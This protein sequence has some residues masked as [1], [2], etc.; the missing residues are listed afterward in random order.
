MKIIYTGSIDI[1][2][3]CN[4]RCRHCYNESGTGHFDEL[5]AEQLVSIAHQL[6]EMHLD[7][8]CICGGEPLVRLPEAMRVLETLR[9]HDQKMTI[10][11]VSNGLIWTQEIASRLAGAG[12]NRVQFSLDGT[13]DVSYDFIRQSG[14]RR[15]LVLDAIGYAQNA[16]MKVMVAAIPHTKNLA[17]FQE[18]IEL[19]DRMGVSELRVQPLMPLGR[20][21]ENYRELRIAPDQQAALSELLEKENVARKFDISWG[22]PID[23]FLAFDE[24]DYIPQLTINAYGEILVTPYLPISIWDL[25]NRSL[26]EYLSKDIPTKA[27][28]HPLIKEAISKVYMVDDLSSEYPG[29]P[30]LSTDKTINLADEILAMEG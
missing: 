12:L 10:S 13:T 18:L 8:L 28:N 1:T 2:Y 21:E 29:L 7:S 17:E 26:E 24:L 27:L 30:C 4:L 6:G 16:G 23:H 19:C 9:Q 11:M 15:K 3:K 14:G 20:G 25:K 5:T 22:D